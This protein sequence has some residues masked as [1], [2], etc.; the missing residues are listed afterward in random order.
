[1]LPASDFVRPIAPPSRG[2]IRRGWDFDLGIVD[3]NFPPGLNRP[4]FAPTVLGDGSTPRGCN[5]YQ[6]CWVLIASLAGTAVRRRRTS[7]AGTSARLRSFAGSTSCRSRR[8]R[9]DTA[10]QEWR[11][12]CG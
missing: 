10:T 2:G 11:F 12:P 1:M 3:S 6:D 7:L 5:N 8:K 4:A 9:K